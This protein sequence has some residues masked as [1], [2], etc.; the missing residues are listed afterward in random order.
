MGPSIFTGRIRVQDPHAQLLFNGRIDFGSEE[1]YMDFIAN[2]DRLDLIPLGF[3]LGDSI[4][5]ISTILT[6]KAKGIN[7]DKL[8]G[9]LRFENLRMRSADADHSF[10]DVLIQATQK[11]AGKLL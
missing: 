2:I 9:E 7:P 5:Q 8:L 3:V 11:G 4:Q 10:G 6:V 1:P